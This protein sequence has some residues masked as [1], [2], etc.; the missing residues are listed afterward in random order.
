VRLLSNEYT[1]QPLN[2]AIICLQTISGGNCYAYLLMFILWN[3]RQRQLR[4]LR[5]SFS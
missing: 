2:C 5:R 3:D 1:T 4:S